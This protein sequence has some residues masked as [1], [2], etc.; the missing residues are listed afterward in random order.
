MFRETIPVGFPD[1]ILIRLIRQKAT[2]L[3]SVANPRYA[4][5]C[6]RN[7]LHARVIHEDNKKIHKY[8][9]PMSISKNHTFSFSAYLFFYFADPILKSLYL[10]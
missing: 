3:H 7:M 10:R 5:Q 4:E 9:A 8:R 1:D 2:N 6:H